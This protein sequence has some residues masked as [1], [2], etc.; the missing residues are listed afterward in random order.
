MPVMSAV[1][2]TFC[3]NPLWSAAAGR[4]VLPWALSGTAPAGDV[5]EIG[6]GGGGM[7]AQ[8]LRHDPAIRLTLTDLDP[9]MTRRAERR[10]AGRAAVTAADATRLPFPDG[11]FDVVLSFLM[12]HHVVQWEDAVREAARVLRPGGHFVGYDLLDTAPSR[13]VH[14]LDRSAHRL[15]RSDEFP[16]A[17]R[18]AG[19]QATRLTRGIAGSALRFIA[20][21]P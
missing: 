3:R 11:T 10:L 20:T 12:L 4:F 13:L 6:G 15:V 17:L 7:A 9:A 18:G 16:A 19:L 14:K 8:L 5:L 1:E 2:R 21:K